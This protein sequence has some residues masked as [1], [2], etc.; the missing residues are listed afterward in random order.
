M[1]GQDRR[2]KGARRLRDAARRRRRHGHRGHAAHARLQ[3]VIQRA[4]LHVQSSEGGHGRNVLVAI[5]GEGLP[6][7][8]SPQGSRLDVV[9]YLTASPR[10]RRRQDSPRKARAEVRA[11]EAQSGGAR[12]SPRAST[13]SHR[14]QIVLIGREAETRRIVQICAGAARDNPLLVGEAGV[15]K[16]AIAEGW[17]SASSTT[18][19]RDP[20]KGAGVRPRHGRSPPAPYRGDS[21]SA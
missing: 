7:S 3:R 8:T 5:Y 19:F 20:V 15:N 14:R 12:A 9:N 13:S 10:R 6:R 4:I 11:P 18:R 17:R 16:T 2:L 1:R 21:S